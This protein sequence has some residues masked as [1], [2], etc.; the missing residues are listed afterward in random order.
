MDAAGPKTPVP[1]KKVG[2]KDQSRVSV[3]A[4]SSEYGSFGRRPIP[5]EYKTFERG[6]SGGWGF[7]IFLFLLFAATVGGFYY[8]NTRPPVVQG[9]SVDMSVAGPDSVV[10]G[11]EVTYTLSYQNKDV[12]ALRT[13]ELDVQ[14]PDGF[15]YDSSSEKPTGDTATTWNLDPLDPGQKK[16]LTIKGQLVGLKDQKQLAVFRLS[17][18]PD[19]INSD[20][21]AKKTV[22]TL[23][24][25]AQIDVTL[26]SPAKV[27]AGQNVTFTATLKDL[28]ANTLTALDINTVLPKDFDIATTDPA[29]VDGHW[30]GDVT[31]DKPL[32]LKINAKVASDGDGPQAWVMEISQADNGQTRK[33]LHKELPVLVVSPDVGIDLKINGQSSGFD[34]DYGEVLNYELKVTN[35]GTSPITDVKVT[36]LMDSDVID[37]KNVQSTGT[38]DKDSI[39]W[40]KDQIPGLANM[41]PGDQ[42]LIS[43][44]APLLQKG[45]V[46]RATVDTLITVEL[47]GLP[48]WQKTSS[49]FVVSV[50][51]GLVFSQNLY[52]NLGGQ[53]VGSGQLP[54]VT[55]EKTVYLVAWSLDSGSQDFDTVS[56]SAFLPPKVTFVSTGD[57][58]E[59]TIKYDPDTN[60]LEWQINNFSSKLLPLKATFTVKLVPTDEDKG[61][62]MQVLNPATIV[63][64]GQEVF[65]SKSFGIM[66]N[67]VITT[68]SGDTGTVIE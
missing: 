21:E 7:I 62:I 65:Q 36:G 64:S 16:E 53:K 28:T 2:S 43:W 12:V 34:S 41:E 29:L 42:V 31:V 44:K 13:A 57:V 33:L 67:Q 4:M 8:W 40:T 66:T 63:A 17:Y 56:V 10:S 58:D 49:V 32:V 25:D 38:A 50:G 1:L 23:I 48:N 35:Q 6:H 5:E 20:F 27:L 24:S 59:G 52:W 47:D 15:Y 18:R 45:T 37:R 51:Q 22:E 68:Q 26:D 9:D 11:S 39:V 54:P 61:T 60:R 55:N 30:K 46:G 19:N 3:R 14:W